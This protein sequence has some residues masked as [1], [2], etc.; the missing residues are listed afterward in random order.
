[1]ARRA[2]VGLIWCVALYLAIL[3]T[4]GLVAGNLAAAHAEP[5][6]DP[7]V[8]GNDAGEH[9]RETA[10]PFIAFAVVGL[11]FL[12]LRLGYLPGARRDRAAITRN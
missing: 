7:A 11:V 2:I 10:G 8:V 5:G 4:V 6:Q 12:S 9:A 1:M 3:F